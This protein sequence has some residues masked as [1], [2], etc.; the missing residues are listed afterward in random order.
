MSQIGLL[1]A[2]FMS[3]VA[4][5]SVDAQLTERLAHIGFRFTP[6]RQHVYN[7]LLEKRDHPTADEVYLRSKHGMSDISLATVYNC[8]DA[9]VKCGLVRQV[10]L[11]RA[12]SR[13]CPNMR[14]HFHFFCE[15]C[16]GIYDIDHAP[17]AP[18][19]CPVPRGFRVHHMDVTL[20]GLCPACLPGT[21]SSPAH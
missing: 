16:G 1:S 11:D 10:N 20:R 15:T 8:L 19:A 21:N 2:D 3:T 4:Y 13:Y 12:A 14:D 5:T 18:A 6:Q 9:L 17:G 7:V